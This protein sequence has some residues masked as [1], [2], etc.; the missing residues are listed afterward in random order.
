LKRIY[1]KSKER[2]NTFYTEVSPLHT[3]FLGEEL[4]LV[5]PGWSGGLREREDVAMDARRWRAGAGGGHPSIYIYI[6]GE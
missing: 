5:G 2:G 3:V 6:K 1:I 4:T